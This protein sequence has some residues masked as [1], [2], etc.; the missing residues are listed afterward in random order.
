MDWFTTSTPV[1]YFLFIYPV[2]IKM[3]K[4]QLTHASLFWTV[5]WQKTCLFLLSTWAR[6]GVCHWRINLAITSERQL[7]SA[8]RTARFTGKPTCYFLFIYFSSRQVL[9]F[10]AQFSRRP[11]PP[12]TPL[13]ELLERARIKCKWQ[14]SCKFA[15]VANA[16]WKQLYTCIW[17]GVIVLGI[18]LN[19]ILSTPVVNNR[20]CRVK[21][22]KLWLQPYFVG[23]RPKTMTWSR[24]YFIYFYI[25]TYSCILN[26]F[27]ACS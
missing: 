12:P 19:A 17:F 14:I 8:Q 6:D 10:P 26:Y 15:H 27:Y 13:S 16:T 18:N 3:N 4:A 24:S 11:P 1:I 20:D 21:N 2:L 25:F 7:A 23:K 5:E 9:F 22:K